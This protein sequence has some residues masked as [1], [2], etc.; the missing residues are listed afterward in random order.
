MGTKKLLWLIFSLFSLGAFQSSAQQMLVP[1]GSTWKYLANGSNQG[2]TWNDAFYD[3][4]TWSQGPAPLGY[5]MTGIVTNVGFGPSSTNKYVTTYFRK[6]VTVSQAELDSFDSLRVSLN[7][8]DGGAVYINGVEVLRVKLPAGA[9]FN[10]LATSP[11]VGSTPANG[12]V[13]VPKSLLAAG[14]NIIAV[15]IHQQAVTSS[16]KY[17]DLSIQKLKNDLILAAAGSEWKYNDQ[18]VALASDWTSNAFD[19]NTWS[20]GNG[21]FGYGN[22]DET[23]VVSFGSD[24]VN[25][26][27]T[28]YFRKSFDVASVD[29][30]GSLKLLLK[31]DDGAV[32]YLNGSD[33]FR[34]N[35]PNGPVA[36]STNALDY[37]EGAQEDQWITIFLPTALLNIGTNVIAVEIHKYTSFESDLRFDMQIALQEVAVAQTP[38]SLYI[39]CDPTQS[40]TIGC[41]TSVLPQ[42]QTP[43][44]IIPSTHTFQLIAK[45]GMSNFYTNSTGNVPTNHDFTG[46]IPSNGS[47]TQGILSINHENDPGDVSLVSLH[48]DDVDQVW[49]RDSARRVDWSQLVRT[50]RNCSGGVT[51][52]G[53]VVTSEETYNTGDVNGDGYTD[54]GWQVEIDPIS[55]K[56][57]DHDGDGLPDKVWAMGRMSHENIAISSDSLTAYQTEDGGTSGVYKYVMDVKAQLSAGTLYVLKRDSPTSTTGEWVQVPNTTQAQRNT[58]RDAITALGGTNWGGPE[59][60]EIGP[61]G[62]MYFTSKNNG[63]IWRFKDDGMTVSEIEPWVTNTSY[64]IMHANGTTNENFGTGID[65]LSFDGEGNLWAQQDGGRGHI[66]VIRPDHTPA[67]P[68]V[69]IF[70]ITPTGSESSGLTFTPDF[71][72]GFLS[73][74]GA[75][76]SNST[77][78]VD[79]AGSNVVFNASSTF[80][81][82]RK[83]NLGFGARRPIV[84]LGDSVFACS[85]ATLTGSLNP[86]ILNVWTG[87]STSPTLTVTQTGWYTL[88]TYANNGKS[89]VD[90]V[91]VTIYPNPEAPVLENA[92]KCFAQTAPELTAVGSSVKWYA[93]AAQSNLLIEN[94]TYV[95]NEEEVGSYTYYATQT[96]VNG[97]VS[98]VASAVYM[99]HE[100]PAMPL[101]QN[102]QICFGNEAPALEATGS[103][104]N[105]YATS[106]L[107]VN[108]ATGAVY[109]TELT[110]AGIYT[111]YTT[112][113]DANGCTSAALEVQLTIFE[114]PA[115][116]MV[117][118]AENCFGTANATLSASGSSVQWYA[119]A[120]LNNLIATGA[121]Y[122]STETQAGS[123]SYFATQTDAN[124]CEST[125]AQVQFTVHAI[126]S[127]PNAQDQQI[128]FGQATPNLTASGLNV[129]WYSNAELTELIATGNVYVSSQANV[130]SYTYYVTQTN[131]V[132]CASPV[133]E[134]TL[135]INDYP[136]APQIEGP[137]VYCANEALSP[138]TAD[139]TN[140]LWYANSLLNAPI[141]Q[142]NSFTPNASGTYYATQAQNACTSDAT[143][144]TVVV[145]P[146][147]EVALTGLNSSYYVNDIPVVV[148]GIPQ[149]G[150]FN[151]S[152]LNGTYFVPAEAGVGGPYAITY[153]YTDATTGCSNTAT[154]L[155]TVNAILGV[156]TMPNGTGINLYP[157]PANEE[158]NLQ[159]LSAQGE[160]IDLKM[161]DAAGKILF[162]Q[163]V[164]GINQE[165]YSFY[166]NRN[167][168][169]LASGTYFLHVNV[170]EYNAVLKVIF[171]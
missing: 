99:I 69:D 101:A 133:E 116:P 127:A 142:G 112:Q 48:L 13:T 64:P 89:N 76:S 160:Q 59:D 61:D 97:C 95:S 164:S 140:V 169:N 49:V 8:D 138:L 20:T 130:G 126:P 19:D 9:A 93:D 44:L 150:V 84:E 104:I 154:N 158:M 162:T 132:G 121:T 22:G 35:M 128:C 6:T 30:F 36:Y 119:D 46:F 37:V 87:G 51:P 109:S 53:T 54:R 24:P 107:S 7:Y 50:T 1:F 72:F 39:A 43:G 47:S 149:G 16:D 96:D 31:R 125:P 71:K 79:A 166:L 33:V 83:E 118:G 92:E 32:V 65:N 161:M 86:D 21:V 153:T 45:T 146:L 124:S 129:N 56:I 110:D 105:W 58:V 42:V 78:L 90:S 131:Q 23:T 11:A 137:T 148:T 135:T 74:M 103:N 75:S 111:F 26:H 73:V 136:A 117:Q 98:E 85:S 152:G 68:K 60:I 88:T 123:Y 114:L 40:Q 4:A 102:E 82:A 155:V 151:G 5:T 108:I 14:D 70:A 52:W 147:P 17:F 141:A 159:I 156:F 62:K 100:L 170:N 171:N 2:T 91:F 106:D 167:E 134:V 120:A 28:T 63:I 29:G 38:S 122:V 163:Q 15:E 168:L 10:T 34:S 27:M 143:S 18:G 12:Q 144:I 139:G 67:V 25:K 57:V 41:F 115:S 81:I 157:N 94:N 80:V 113:T 145:N 77:V 165:V 55:G 3:D 66:W